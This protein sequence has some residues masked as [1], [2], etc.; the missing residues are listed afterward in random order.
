M[1]LQLAHIGYTNYKE[2]V[3]EEVSTG[4][5]NIVLLHKNII[6][7]QNDLLGKW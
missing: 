6:T 4:I 7:L 2:D 1:E 5:C 3:K